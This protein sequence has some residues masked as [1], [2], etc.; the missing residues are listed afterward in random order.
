MNFLRKKTSWSNIQLGLLKICIGSIG[1]A[2]GAYF[3]DYLEGYIFLLI[4]LYLITGI[5]LFS[6]WYKQLKK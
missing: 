6:C 5:Y 4:A 2:I 3:H 1:A